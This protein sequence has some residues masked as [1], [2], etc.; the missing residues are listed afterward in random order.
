MASASSASH[1]QDSAP[2]PPPPEPPPAPGAAA[3]VTVW[4]ASPVLPLP[5]LTA[6]STVKVPAAFGVRVAVIEVAKLVPLA[7]LGMIPPPLVS[8]HS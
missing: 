8:V 5:S 7:T 1:G 3:T 2:P 4:L 6:S